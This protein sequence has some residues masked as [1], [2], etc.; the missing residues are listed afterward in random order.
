M[1]SIDPSD[2]IARLE[3]MKQKVVEQ[4]AMAES[5]GELAQLETSVDDEINKALGPA[6]NPTQ[7][8]ALLKLKAKMAEQEQIKQSTTDSTGG[9]ASD[10]GSAADEPSTPPPSEGGMSELDKLKQKLKDAE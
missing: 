8:D 9:S 10:S 4:E 2:T 6:S 7:S 5:Y 1:A 3:R